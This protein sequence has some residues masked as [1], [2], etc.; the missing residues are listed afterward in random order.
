MK[1]SI[2]NI[3]FLIFLVIAGS[4]MCIP[5][6]KEVNAY[7][8]SSYKIDGSTVFIKL[9]RNLTE[10]KYLKYTRQE[11]SQEEQSAI[12]DQL[13]QLSESI[14]QENF[15]KTGLVLSYLVYYTDNDFT[16]VISK[17]A[18]T[19]RVSADSTIPNPDNTITFNFPTAYDTL[20]CR[21]TISG[22]T[23]WTIEQ[24]AFLQQSV[25]E[26]TPIYRD[27]FGPPFNAPDRTYLTSHVIHTPTATSFIGMTDPG[28]AR[29]KLRDPSSI[30]PAPY[31]QDK[32]TG[33]PYKAIFWHEANHAYYG[34]N[35]FTLK[36]T[37][38]AES[39]AQLVSFLVAKSVGGQPNE[40][41]FD[42]SE[43]EQ[44]NN[45]RLSSDNASTTYSH[46]ARY[47]T[48][49]NVWLKLYLENP[50]ILKEFNS[51]IA[52]N[53]LLPEFKASREGLDILYG[54]ITTP[55]KTVEGKPFYEWY[56]D[57]Y[58]IMKTRGTKFGIRLSSSFS[59]A[60]MNISYVNSTKSDDLP[61]SDLSLADQYNYK[62]VNDKNVT[63]YQTT[64][65]LSI[66][67]YSSINITSHFGSQLPEGKICA[68]ATLVSNGVKA[69]SCFFFKGNSTSDQELGITGIIGGIEDLQTAGTVTIYPDQNQPIEPFATAVVNGGF[70]LPQL[71]STGGR[72]KL[73]YHPANPSST[74][75]IRYVTK[76]EN[77]YYFSIINIE[78][79]PN[80][81]QLSSSAIV[82]GTSTIT[83]GSND[84][85]SYFVKQQG[86]PK[87]L[88]AKSFNN[89]GINSVAMAPLIGTTP[90]LTTEDKYYLYISKPDGIGTN[91]SDYSFGS[92]VDMYISKWSDKAAID[93]GET[94]TYKIMA[95]N[96]TS[97][98]INF[99]LS[100]SVANI[101]S[102]GF[103]QP[104]SISDG[105]SYDTS[106]Q[107]IEWPQ[108]SLQANESKKV[109]FKMI[110]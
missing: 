46:Y 32:L 63:I 65:P 86:K 49:P 75:I 104:T 19:N 87:Y 98:S 2:L 95:T 8:N 1:K 11:L 39:I 64:N 20:Y 103:S 26:M 68:E 17:S 71:Y 53:Y 59:N 14:L 55:G 30:A 99:T 12:I 67:G 74:D 58:T 22:C 27:I 54:L 3:L 81:S 56:A 16:P 89:S 29:I 62:L 57:Q 66:N 41:D 72:L 110:Y 21:Q 82:N 42:R 36:S 44:Y 97:T 25:N 100:D 7:D 92:V 109:I 80:I 43:Y 76:P 108:M 88:Y 77:N 50:N 105:G 38:W 107:T 13:D 91:G 70:R 83:L 34:N 52:S 61:S 51:V 37:E 15:T 6:S 10:E 31:D 40:V 94:I 28:G 101:V 33:M 93:K 35:N 45:P 4:S 23:P 102:S 90:S 96:M 79:S 9:P 24:A 47:T 84:S 73:V 48:S 18:P 85:A 60:T 69:S 106:T 78:K 5:D